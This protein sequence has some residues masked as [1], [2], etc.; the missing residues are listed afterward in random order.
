M[1]AANIIAYLLICFPLTSISALVKKKKIRLLVLFKSFHFF[2]C[3][4]LLMTGLS[5]VGKENKVVGAA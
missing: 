4:L 1:G 5:S 3:F 2:L